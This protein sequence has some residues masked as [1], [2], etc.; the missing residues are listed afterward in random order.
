MNTLYS[1]N[2]LGL[3]HTWTDMTQI[4]PTVSRTISICQCDVHVLGLSV[5]YLKEYTIC[6]PCLNKVNT[7]NELKKCNQDNRKYKSRSHVVGGC[8]ASSQN[9]ISTAA[10]S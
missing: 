1:C 6:G 4:L 8:H 2:R 3:Y 10:F 7:Y 9:K 5:E